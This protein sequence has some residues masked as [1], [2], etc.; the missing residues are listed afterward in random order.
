[1]T[2]A[3][4]ETTSDAVTN[5]PP[6]DSPTGATRARGLLGRV[7]AGLPT[8]L[9]LAAFAAVAFCGHRNGWKAPKFS[10]A[11]AVSAAGEKEDWCTEHGVPESTCI[12]CHPELVGGNA[13]DWCKEHG[14]AESKCTLCHPEI[15]TKGVAADWCKE[16][17]VP[18]SSCPQCHPEIAVKGAV[19]AS[20]TGATVTLAPGATRP[21]AASAGGIAAPATVPAAGG[22]NATTGAAKS[23]RNPQACQTHQLRVHFASPGAVAKAG[24]KLGPVVER[25]MAASLTANGEVGYDRTRLAQVASP[26]AGRAWRVDREVGQKVKKGEV[27]ALV[28]AAEVGKAKAELLQALA[29]VDLRKKTLTR[30]RSSAES[31]FRTDA[32][33]Q[34]GEAA[35]RSADIRL[36][37][38]Q[39]AMVN[40][41][42]SPSPDELANLTRSMNVQ[43]LGLSAE[44]VAT[45]DPKSTS[46]NLIPL[47][48]PLDGIVTERN[49]VAGEVVEVSKPLF[50]V[51]DTSRMWL[52]VDVMP[53]EARRVAL[54][55]DVS[56]QSDGNPDQVG[57][58]VVKWVSTAMDEQTRTVKLRAELD[59]ADGRL[60]ANTFGQARIT[61]RQSPSAVAVP[62]EAL[63]WEGCCHVVFVR[64][65]DMIYQTRKVRLGARTGPYAE[66]VAGLLPGEVVAT[67]GSSVLKSEILKSQLGAGCTDGH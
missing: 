35:L 58:G 26:L 41:G 47:L 48:A 3:K 30:L 60:L 37:N 27:L 52:T 5:A 42:L 22:G 8:V 50:V 20:E 28:D 15:L 10:N 40:L 65:T 18:E 51:A 19:P 46:A 4:P 39:R 49:V 57:R 63:Q 12:K 21:P 64:L 56:F 45:L 59:N 34:E 6:S 11:T 66:V 23:G 29:D 1:M 24:V 36:F 38:A 31:G 14:V 44:V 32:E 25:P 2:S 62:A 13:A 16:H 43:M 67:A 7:T 17:G 9:V 55:Q 54:G 53:T 61:I 33:M